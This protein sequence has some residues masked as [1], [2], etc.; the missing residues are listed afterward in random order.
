[1]FFGPHCT[2]RGNHGEGTASFINLSDFFGPIP[3]GS[4]SDC[5][6]G[7]FGNIKGKFVGFHGVC[8]IMTLR[9]KKWKLV[10][11]QN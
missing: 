6:D 3:N 2:S 10:P 1:M 7:D 11:A 5:N 4:N 9:I 8:F